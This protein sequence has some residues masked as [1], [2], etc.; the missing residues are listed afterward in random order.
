MADDLPVLKSG[1]PAQLN[2]VVR[3]LGIIAVISTGAV[4]G[5]AIGGRLQPDLYVFNGA[6]AV[7]SSDGDT[8]IFAEKHYHITA[9]RDS[10]PAAVATLNS[11]GVQL[12][13]VKFSNRL[14]LKDGPQTERISIRC[15]SR[16]FE[17][18]LAMV[19]ALIIPYC[20]DVAGIKVLPGTLD[21]R[22]SYV[23]AGFLVGGTAA[24]LMSLLC[25]PGLRQCRDVA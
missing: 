22:F 13:V 4:M 8:D 20:N 21:R 5:A 23:V 15:A 25:G 18:P 1:R 12:S 7:A 11:Q 17:M 19:N 6:F 3:K 16:S 2:G 9:I 10:I 14:T 24:A